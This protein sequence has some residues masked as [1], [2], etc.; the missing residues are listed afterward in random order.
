M[1]SDEPVEFRARFGQVLTVVAAVVCVVTLVAIAVEDTVAALRWAPVLALVAT[2]VWAFYG[3]P[4]VVVDAA[5]VELR[6]VTRT[7]RLPWPAVQRVDTKYALT[8]ETA[9]GTYAAWAAP[10]PSRSTTVRA[11]PEDTR[12]LPESSYIGGGLRPGDLAGTASG[13]AAAYIRRCLDQLRD[14]GHL[15]EPR[16]ERDRPEVTWHV[17][18]GLLLAGL[19]A[20]AVLT[21]RLL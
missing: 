16:L 11:T 4:A 1:T 14:A 17:L 15:D 10:A 8:V 3:R 12:Y 5:G 19:T 13:D 6:N 9:Y 20:L 18:P 2:G 7:V 21:P